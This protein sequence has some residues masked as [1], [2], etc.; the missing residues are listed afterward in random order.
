MKSTV[1][2][3]WRNVSCPRESL[4]FTPDTVIKETPRSIGVSYEM[5]NIFQTSPSEELQVVTGW[6]I[7]SRVKQQ[8]VILFCQGNDGNISHH[9]DL[10]KFVHDHLPE[11]SLFM[12]DYL[13]FGNSGTSSVSASLSGCHFSTWQAY[14]WLVFE[15]MV[16]PSNIIIWSKEFGSIFACELALTMGKKCSGLVLDSPVSSV[17][18]F[19]RTQW[20]SYMMTWPLALF[21]SG[22]TQCVDVVKSLVESSKTFVLVMDKTDGCQEL[23][24]AASKN[25]VISIPKSTYFVYAETIRHNLVKGGTI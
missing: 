21:E 5:V 15:K 25:I 6:W 14:R 19:I 22:R 2:K 9:L 7:P 18:D 8:R 13:G 1:Y 23:R 24:N 3:L 4:F 12:F 10:V 16:D 11:C 17:K 20:T